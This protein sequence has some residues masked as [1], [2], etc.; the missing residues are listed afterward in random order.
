[1]KKLVIHGGT[2]L[3]GQVRINGSKNASLPI[4]IATLLTNQRCRIQRV[5]H[6]DDVVTILE[7]LKLIG[8]RPVWSW[9]LNVESILPKKNWRNNGPNG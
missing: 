2:R 5:P 7:L 1:M 9:I 8:K 3:N 6:L 4:M